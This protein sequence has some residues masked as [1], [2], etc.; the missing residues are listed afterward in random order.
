M[1]WDTQKTG[2]LQS[3][4]CCI[5]KTEAW[6]PFPFSYDQL[7]H[8]RESGT[9]SQ[10]HIPWSDLMM[11]MF[12]LFAVLYV[13]ASSGKQ[14]PEPV[15]EKPV[16]TISQIYDMSRNAFQ[17][18]ALKKLGSVELIPDRAIKILLTSD[19]LFDTGKADLKPGAMDAL[20]GIAVILKEVPHQVNLTGHTDNIPIHTRYFPSNWELST[21]RASAVAR[22]LIEKMHIPAERFSVS[23]YADMHPLRPN[24]SD[25]DRAVNRRVEIMISRAKND[26]DVRGLSPVSGG[27]N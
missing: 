10:W 3:T 16:P 8:S 17:Q 6:E 26:E 19:L 1:N 4:H 18:K 11:T 23:G 15:T 14:V 5:T 25:E 21:A 9:R 2:I 27:R 22:F 20:T 13:Y 12:V 24:D 7:F